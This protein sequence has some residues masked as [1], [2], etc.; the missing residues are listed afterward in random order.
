[1]WNQKKKSTG[2]HIY[3]IE[4]ESWR[5]KTNSGLP[6]DKQEEEKL[7]DGVWHI[8]TIMYKINNR[9]LLNSTRN[10]PQFSVVAYITKES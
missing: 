7:R 5:Q 3:K 1:M 2:E 4:V 8:Y 6:E 9:N 10:S